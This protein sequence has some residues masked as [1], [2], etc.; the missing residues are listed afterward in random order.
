MLQDE[1]NKKANEIYKEAYQ[2]SL[3]ELANLYRDGELDI[4]PEFQ[5]LYR[6]SNYQKTKLIESIMLNIP[7]P[8]IYVSQNDEGV[9]DVIDGV[10]RLS[11]IFQ[12][13][14]I[15]KD[16]EGKL[17][18]PLVLL[19][20]KDLPSFEGMLWNSADERHSFTR[21]QQL[22]MKRARIDVTIL[23]KNSDSKTKY[24]LFQRLNT[25]GSHLSD[26]EVRNCLIIMENR[27][28]YYFVL[29][30]SKNEHFLNCI[31]ITDRKSDEQYRLELIIRLLIADHVHW[32]DTK[33]YED[34]QELLD[35]EIL[36]CCSDADYPFE[37]VKDS[38][39]KT[40]ALLDSSIGE[41]AFKKYV[42]EDDK[43]KG[44]FFLAA[45]DAISIGVYRNIEDLEKREDAKSCVVKKVKNMV[46]NPQF[47]ES[48]KHG[49]RVNDRY[50]KLSDWGEK[51]FNEEN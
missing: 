27:D 7:I 13:M 4:H 1:I 43:F 41:D 22:E 29:E 28:F 25:G 47:I 8:P 24:E 44:G 26:Q 39:Q 45:Y 3:G 37:V 36:K 21:E 38:F 9:W 10:Q 31:P 6:W 51:Y 17:I 19:K 40:F 15:L 2:M 50:R 16:E 20:T 35:E 5:R 49:V 32:E 33:E 34:N 42:S 46:T 48:S 14:G 30:L 23:K 18:E 11:T 12:F